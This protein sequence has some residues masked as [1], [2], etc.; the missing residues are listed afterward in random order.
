[1]QTGLEHQVLEQAEDTRKSKRASMQ[2]L[3]RVAFVRS[4]RMTPQK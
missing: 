3:F 1:M 4:Q 2:T